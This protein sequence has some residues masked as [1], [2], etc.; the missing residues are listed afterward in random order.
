MTV[1]A[2]YEAGDLFDVDHVEVKD[3]L[4]QAGRRPPNLSCLWAD[5]NRKHDLVVFLGEAAPPPA[6]GPQGPG[7]GRR[8]AAGFKLRRGGQLPCFVIARTPPAGWRQG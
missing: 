4:L 8:E 2:E 5:P 7:L 6:R 3:G 1:I